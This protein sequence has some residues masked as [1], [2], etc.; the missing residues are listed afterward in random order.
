LEGLKPSKRSTIL[1]INLLVGMTF[2]RFFHFNYLVGEFISQL[3]SIFQ[4][5]QDIDKESDEDD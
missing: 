3:S 5:L 2:C 4:Y 1:K